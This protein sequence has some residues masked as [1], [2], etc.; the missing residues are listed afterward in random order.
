MLRELRGEV[1]IGTSQC[2]C[3]RTMLMDSQHHNLIQFSKPLSQA[4]SKIMRTQQQGRFCLIV[5]PRNYSVPFL[6]LLYSFNSRW[7]TGQNYQLIMQ[8]KDCNIDVN[9]T[10]CVSLS[11]PSR[12][13]WAKITIWRK[14]AYFGLWM[15]RLTA[16][17][18]FGLCC[19]HHC[20]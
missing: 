13:F 12:N 1:I 11:W 3:H 5:I 10:S 18:W 15:W 2:W 8:E 17:E 19:W 20:W 6:P 9:D 7:D 14:Q 16:Q 4:T